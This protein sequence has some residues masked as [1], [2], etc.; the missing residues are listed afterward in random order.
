MEKDTTTKY[1]LEEVANKHY[2]K[3]DRE[4]SIHLKK[5]IE[6]GLNE[7]EI[8]DSSSEPDL[9]VEEIKSTYK[10]TNQY[11]SSGY[12]SSSSYNNFSVGAVI[13]SVAIIVGSILMFFLL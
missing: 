3:K 9:K 5:N 6:N 2:K 13:G 4:N 11:Q 7:E 1:K 8:E 10:K 12:D